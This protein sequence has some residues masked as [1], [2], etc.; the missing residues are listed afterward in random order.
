MIQPQVKRKI[1]LL[2]LSSHLNQSEPNLW[3]SVPSPLGLPRS[4]SDGLEEIDS[5]VPPIWVTAIHCTI[6]K[7]RSPIDF[8]S[9]LSHKH[10]PEFV[11][12]N[13]CR[14]ISNYPKKV[15]PRLM[16]KSTHVLALLAWPTRPL[17]TKASRIWLLKH[18]YNFTF[19]SRFDWVMYKYLLP[20]FYCQ[21]GY[22]MRPQAH[23]TF[24]G[25]AKGGLDQISSMFWKGE[26]YFSFSSVAKRSLTWSGIKDVYHVPSTY[27]YM[28]LLQP[29]THLVF[30]R[31][32]WGTFDNTSRRLI[33]LRFFSNGYKMN[34]EKQVIPIRRLLK[35][36]C[37][38]NI[39]ILCI[40]YN[41]HKR[42]MLFF[43]LMDIGF[44][45]F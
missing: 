15:V 14:R 42:W 24:T 30:V 18:A 45:M 16:R 39:Q 38:A 33:Y 20:Y 25:N 29:N 7:F 27:I 11:R 40:T 28:Y 21:F 8:V 1:S 3:L 23:Y 12:V 34:T 5:Q 31:H 10:P 19:P 36:G 4:P 22:P 2:L 26:P 44:R 9:V 43:R 6:G 13:F 37:L 35:Q 17:G 32:F 41:V